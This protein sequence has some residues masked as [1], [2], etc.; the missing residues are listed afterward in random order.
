[1]SYPQRPFLSKLVMIYDIVPNDWDVELFLGIGTYAASGL[2]LN[3]SSCMRVDLESN[4]HYYLRYCRA[5]SDKNHAKVSHLL[6]PAVRSVILGVGWG[7]SPFSLD[8][9]CLCV[10]PSSLDTRNLRNHKSAEPAYHL[11]IS[12][13]A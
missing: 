2:I 1:M 12:L 6:L 4:L 11:I 7:S 8:F 3:K 5:T 9:V 13:V 10:V